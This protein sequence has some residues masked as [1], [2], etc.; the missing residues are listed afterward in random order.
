MNQRFLMVL[1][2]CLLVNCIHADSSAEPVT[3]YSE[4][5][6]DNSETSFNVTESP[7]DTFS[8]SLSYG[9]DLKIVLNKD[10]YVPGD[11]LYANMTLQNMEDFPIVDAYL[12]VEIVEGKEHLYP[13]D[14]S[15]DNNVFYEAVVGGI[16]LAPGCS[17][18]VPFSYTLPQDLRGG[19]YLFEVYAKTK[20]TSLVGL[21]FIFL[22][23][24]DALFNISGT[25]NF[26]FAKILWNETV[27]DGEAGQV[28]PSVNAS[29]LFSGKVYLRNEQN[30]KADYI[31]NVTICRWDDTLCGPDEFVSQKQYPLSLNPGEVSAV[32]VELKAP[33]KPD[34]YAIRL[35]LSENGRTV[36]IYRSRI[37]VL[38]PTAKIRKMALDK[39]YLQKG[40]SEKIMLL[41]GPSPD[42]YT[43][44]RNANASISIS[45]EGTQ[46]YSDS[47]LIPLLSATNVTAI[48]VP[49]IFEFTSPQ[50]L[51]TYVLCSRI[52][53]DKGELYDSY[54]ITIDPSKIMP[55]ETVINVS[56]D[57]DYAGSVLNVSLCARDASGLAANSKEA[58]LLLNKSGSIEAV[59]DDV[60]LT[61]CSD[62]AL[63]A[64]IGEHTLLVND[65]N[66]NRQTG[67]DIIIIKKNETLLEQ[68]PVCGN[69]LCEPD[70][71]TNG[72]CCTDCE[73]AQ[74]MQCVNNICEIKETTT[75]PMQPRIQPNKDNSLYYLGIALIVLGIL[76]LILRNKSKAK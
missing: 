74:N 55:T 47:K 10:Q 75:E 51:K 56:W 73:C 64:D 37:V 3:N 36:S 11:T 59:K 16:N 39:L 45:V 1:G 40:D 15:D 26:P 9:S 48:L 7:I 61:P 5:V 34:A 13:A 2:L 68:A 41:V 42:G 6:L 23:P 43:D 76:L 19:N 46:V 33:D 70:E 63:N 65:L 66:T 14:Q 18:T 58:V 29:A 22:S 21:P 32:D 52:E 24:M 12:I 69:D 25:G 31:L 38:G 62:I 67:T 57:Y 17:K 54:C 35:E 20:R 28:G 44:V 27:I 4:P 71:E 72:T 53:S 60:M 49:E 8:V 30:S 50:E